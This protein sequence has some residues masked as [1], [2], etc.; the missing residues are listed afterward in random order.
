MRPTYYNIDGKKV[1]AVK[2]V[3]YTTDGE[4]HEKIIESKDRD[5]ILDFIGW[6]E[7]N[8]TVVKWR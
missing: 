5:K 1:E 4:R 2:F 7:T 8:K 6:L 3:Y